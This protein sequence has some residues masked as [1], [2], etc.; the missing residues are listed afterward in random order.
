M[1]STPLLW[2]LYLVSRRVDALVQWDA[3]NPLG[4]LGTTENTYVTRKYY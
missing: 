3:L 4:K 2:G 1:I